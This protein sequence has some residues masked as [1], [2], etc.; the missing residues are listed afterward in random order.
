[1]STV[2][3]GPMANLVDAIEKVGAPEPALSEVEEWVSMCCAQ[4]R[5]NR[6]RAPLVR[7]FLTM[8]YFL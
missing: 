4:A 3:F 8:D 1:M 2:K 7:N 6:P 5:R